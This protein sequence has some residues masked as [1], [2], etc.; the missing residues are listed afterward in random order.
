MVT[1]QTPKHSETLKLPKR[2]AV[3]LPVHGFTLTV[4]ELL[5]LQ[6]RSRLIL[7]WFHYCP[8]IMKMMASPLK[9]KLNSSHNP[10]VK[11]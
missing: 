8:Q 4:T 7:W 5:L 6:R 2:R 1:T 10:A 3:L 9:L 11:S